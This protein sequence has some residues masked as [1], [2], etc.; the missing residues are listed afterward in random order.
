MSAIGRYWVKSGQQ[1]LPRSNR[2]RGQAEA[3]LRKRPP[4]IVIEQAQGSSSPAQYTTKVIHMIP[5]RTRTRHQVLPTRRLIV[6][7]II[8]NS[9]R[10]HRATAVLMRHGVGWRCIQGPRRRFGDRPRHRL[11][12]DRAAAGPGRPRSLGPGAK[13]LVGAEVQLEGAPLGPAPH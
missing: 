5:G 11:R 1:A 8:G 7:L 12:P 9:A 2:I 3:Q 4:N 10:C 6:I 13:G